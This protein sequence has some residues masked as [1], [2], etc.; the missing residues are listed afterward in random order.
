MLLNSCSSVGMCRL[1]LTTAAAE[2][3]Q[4]A[5]ARQLKRLQEE[6]QKL[7]D[8]LEEV[9]RIRDFHVHRCADNIIKQ[10]CTDPSAC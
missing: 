7:E 8:S 6:R 4:S 2:A 3:T 1:I 9:C 10:S 5:S